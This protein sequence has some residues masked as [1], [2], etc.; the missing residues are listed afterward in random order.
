M[1]NKKTYITSLLSAALFLCSSASAQLS[2]DNSIGPNEAVENVLLGEGI[3]VS[4]ITFSGDQNQIGT[5]DAT[6]ANIGIQSGI[7]LGTGDVLF[8]QT[9]AD[10][11]GAGG[12]ENT[13]GSLG[14]GNF[15][16]ND[17]DLDLL[18][19]FDTNDAV[20][21]EFD[22]VPS[23]DS[24]VFNYV[25]G[26]EE[27]NEY[28]CG[29]VND[30]FGFFLSG[31]GISGPFENNAINLAIVPNT[32][33]PVTINT[34]NNGS[35]GNNGT[36]FNC[37]QVSPD[38][39]QNTEYFIDNDLNSDTEAVEY[40]GF[41]VIMTAAASVTCGETYHIK[42]AIA[43]GGD[44]A[45]DSGVFLGASSFSS[46]DV[47]IESSIDDP[48]DNIP[49]NSIVEGCVNGSF[50]VIRP[51][52]TE[53][54]TIQLTY[55]GTST[56]GVDVEII[57]LDVFM[58]AGVSSV[59]IPIIPLADLE[60]EGTETLTLSYT[61]ING[62][63]EQNTVE[64]TVDILDYL[65]PV[66]SLEETIFI[67]PGTSA[68]AIAIAEL[69]LGPYVYDWSSGE[70]TSTVTFNEGD[71]GEYTVDITDYCGG[72]ASASTT[73]EEPEP[74]QIEDDLELCFGATTGPLVSGGTLPYTF[75][76]PEENLVLNN[77]GG[78]DAILP[79]AST[80]IVGDA[81]GELLSIELIFNEC[82]TIIPNVFTPNGDGHNHYFTILGIDGYPKSR[83]LIYNRWGN[84]VFESIDYKNNWAGEDLS[85]GT[86]FYI[87]ERS[88]GLS[89]TG[90]LSLLRK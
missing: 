86:Y 46:N 30:A 50:T 62:C 76:Y 69:G 17:P 16:I 79:G 10:G 28:V 4:G 33:I 39:D 88:D 70:N 89:M 51:N 56:N 60:V 52:S 77:F 14:G 9:G 64:A 82:N 35:V 36:E 8:A 27:Y 32:D 22:F 67:C 73:V 59:V 85:E 40:D 57:E 26:S 6:L 43:D 19:T 49:A 81:C 29:T 42:M 58:E 2:V 54:E 65:D 63:G 20:V 5:F 78:F 24:I 47:F 53:E 7:M 41:T 34:V 55:T 71:A 12:N 38:W 66:V 15:G 61:Y 80:V 45:F 75:D 3:A 72:T 1:S 44:T 68:Q 18:S 48:P 11:V 83:L 25:F 74:L 31:P 37:I 23:G 87:L 90:Q 13:G 84:L 21:L